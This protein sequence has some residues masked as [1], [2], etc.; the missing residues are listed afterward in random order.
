M[1]QAFCSVLCKVIGGT[2]LHL[3]KREGTK[4]SSAFLF[5]VFQHALGQTIQT[6]CP[7][8]KGPRLGIKQTEANKREWTPEQQQRQVRYTVRRDA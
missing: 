2:N 4:Y 7:E 1:A 6:T 5:P 3:P 8:F